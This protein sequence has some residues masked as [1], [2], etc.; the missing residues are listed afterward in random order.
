[1]EN[2]TC[3]KIPSLLS[4]F[5]DTFVDFSVSGGLFL[6]MPPQLQSVPRPKSPP[7]QNHDS[8][9]PIP[10][11]PRSTI[12]T[13]YPSPD[14]LVA[15][16][17][18]HGDLDK[19]KE[20]LRLAG[21]IDSSDRWSG[22]STTLVQIGDVLDRGGN[23]IAILYFL[24]KLKRQAAGC[25]GTIITMNGNHEIMN[26]GSDFRYV[27]A[28]GFKEFTNWGFWYQIGISMKSLCSD[29]INLPE[30]PFEG[31]P[32][33]FRG[34][35][36][37]F[38]EGF[39]A[40]IAALRPNGPISTR[41]LSDNPTVLV[42]GDNVFVHGGLLPS[43]VEYGLERINEE[44]RDWINGGRKSIERKIG[45]SANS[46]VWLRKYSYN[47]AEKCD[48]SM[49]EHVLATIPGARRMIMGHTIQPGGINGVCGNKAIR[50]D[51]GMSKGCEN[52]LPEV[53]EISKD[54]GL[55]VLTS[56]SLYK[57]ENKYEQLVGSHSGKDDLQ[58]SKERPRQMEDLLFS[59]FPCVEH[60]A[61]RMNDTGSTGVG[62]TW[63]VL[64]WLHQA[65]GPSCLIFFFAGYFCQTASRAPCE[66]DL[67]NYEFLIHLIPAKMS[68]RLNTQ[69]LKVSPM[70]EV[71]DRLKEV[72]IH[73]QTKA[74]VKGLVDSGITKIPRCFH[75]PPQTLRGLKPL[76]NGSCEVPVIDFGQ[77]DSDVGDKETVDRVR[78]AAE[79]WGVFQL[80]NHGVPLD[81]MNQ[82]LD[83]TRR[84]HEQPSEVKRTFYSRDRD[85]KVRYFCNGDLLTSKA[86]NWRD[87]VCYDYHDSVLDPN[88][89]PLI[90]R[91]AVMDYMKHMLDL[92]KKL[93]R[94]FSD[95][96][97]LSQDCLLSMECVDTANLL[98][99]YYPSCPE[100]EMTL[101][102][103]KHSD[104]SFL[105]I[106]MQDKMGG[107]QVFHENQWVDVPPATGALVINIGDMMQLITNDKFKS[108]E[109]RVLVSKTGP[110]VSAACFFYPST[111]K[112]YQPYRPL[113]ELIV[114]DKE[115][116]Y[117][118]V[119][120]G[121]YLA[122]Y[123]MKGVD[124]TTAKMEVTHLES[125][126]DL[127]YDLEK[128]ILEFEKAKAGVKGLVD[129]GILKIPHIFYNSPKNLTPKSLSNEDLAQLQVPVI[130]FSSYPE[131]IKQVRKAAENWGFFQVVNHGIPL[132]IMEE[133]LEVTR[134]FH[135][136]PSEVKRSLYTLDVNQSVRFA[137]N[138]LLR[139]SKHADWRD[140]FVCDY[141]DGVLD[142]ETIPLLCR[143]AVN[144]YM[145]H[146]MELKEK[147][148]HLLSEALGLDTNYLSRIE[149]LSCANLVCHYYPPCPEPELTMGAT[150]HS[151][152]FF[153][154]VLVQDNIGGLQVLH[155]NYWVDVKPI[156]GGLI[157]NIADLMQLITNDKFKSVEHRVLAG[158]K[159]PRTSAACFFSAKNKTKSYGS[160]QELQNQEN[161]QAIYKEVSVAEYMRYY[162][163]KGLDGKSGLPH[164]KH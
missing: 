22:G 92:R 88:E 149:C 128:E 35:N 70:G 68:S 6:P 94:A 9:P 25:G 69:T 11:P 50:I 2:S 63:E 117:K 158:K 136:Q 146:M 55:R 64:A 62:H 42:M 18:V 10:S 41:F 32:S 140:S 12:Q 161:K 106:L 45:N 33:E 82:M 101:G 105:T 138:T 109:H 115:A 85:R 107:L 155:Q 37:Q 137:S 71:Y 141:H 76:K 46:P 23:E 104:P 83:G 28:E 87:S 65:I 66:L 113:K 51:V 144:D 59:A 77:F 95:A 15:V 132:G 52:G 142:P 99:H 160:I 58:L 27:T 19:L 127:D 148:S 56:N 111:K 125:G 103:T 145:E 72:I 31:L 75:H 79:T 150:N 67:H 121:E 102:A 133:L 29:T 57:E 8:D 21:L 164:F 53:L 84:F 3:T 48:C 60:S 73:D 30:D 81:T 90:C 126:Q 44:I 119:S 36:K 86:A 157:V 151:D 38:H 14:R 118:E 97:G 5:V 89:I 130:D 116:I 96:L 24:E 152:P 162:K 114:Q 54:S 43:H 108:V 135:E 123:K 147:L 26:I 159:G 131:I 112:K 7:L 134:R 16:G 4:A 61:F 120:A 124:V 156:R 13:H 122:F 39:R 100:P 34:I 20:S 139:A 154:T 49:L 40:R 74:G 153:L 80:V 47:E 129:S 143:K 17:D 98:C 163:S 93:C 110:R 1:M 91:E 78:E